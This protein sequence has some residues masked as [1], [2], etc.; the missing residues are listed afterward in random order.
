MVGLKKLLTACQNIDTRFSYRSP[1][2]CVYLPKGTRHGTVLEH[3]YAVLRQW[4]T[5]KQPQSY[6]R[7]SHDYHALTGAWFEPHGS[8]DTPLGELNKHLASVG[9]PA[10]SALVILQGN[11][12]PGA[13][14]WGC[15][16]NVPHR[17]REGIQR[18]TEW[19]RIVQEVIAHNWSATLPS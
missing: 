3:V 4:A 16:P 13:G 5:T 9:A 19:N 10:L 12:E 1:P 11:N 18:V 6:R 15:A 8:W 17:P 2:T 14:F 7:L